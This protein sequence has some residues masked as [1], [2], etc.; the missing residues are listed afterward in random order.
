MAYGR[1]FSVTVYCINGEVIHID[2]GE[3]DFSC[4]RDDERE[5]N[6]AELT[7][8]GLTADTQNLIAQSG[9]TISVAAG[10]ADEALFTLFQGELINAITVKPGEVYGLQMKLY[11]SLIPFRASITSRTFRKGDSLKQA[12]ILV[13]NDM[14]LGCLV[15]K[16]AAAL[17][18][19]KNISAAALSRDVLTSLCNPVGARWS[20]Q[21]QSIAIT[22]G[23][24]LLQGA[25]IFDP[26]SGLLDAPRLKT[27]TQ[28]R[29]RKQE[30]TK[31]RKVSQ[32]KKHET[33]LYQ[34]PPKNSQ[35]DYSTGARRQIGVIEGLVWD[36]LL[37]GGIDINEQV[38]LS[39]PSLGDGLLVIVK[40]IRHR[41]S[42]RDNGVWRSSWE[43]VCE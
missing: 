31:T 21:Y 39:S 22:A 10:Y 37:R 28:K 3:V 40:K 41:F 8:W 24:S 17:T 16:Q 7:I 23:D 42:T 11:E 32:R 14:G 19:A 35:V 38:E 29:R 36:S 9:S 34:W 20:I 27:H 1:Q 12:A 33:T 4:V 15:S 30:S 5:P 25:A 6:E 13:A 26:E 18:L 2:D 43:G